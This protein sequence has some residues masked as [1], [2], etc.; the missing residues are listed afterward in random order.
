MLIFLAL[1]GCTDP[2]GKGAP[3]AAV[4]GLVPLPAVVEDG[5]GTYVLD[6]AT[7]IAAEGDAAPV[8]A[9]L[10]EALRAGTGLPFPVEPGSAGG[11]VLLIDPSVEGGDEG[12]QGGERLH[13]CDVN[14]GAPD[15]GNRN[16]LLNERLQLQ[17]TT[18]KE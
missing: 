17:R 10:A 14:N 11:V 7:T 6:A 9:L 18:A 3:D 5:E 8:A 1:L 15:S 16:E 2:G 4:P 13:A 12:L